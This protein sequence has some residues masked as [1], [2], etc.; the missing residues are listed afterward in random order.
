MASQRE[1]LIHIGEEH[2]LWGE[3]DSAS[4]GPVRLWVPFAY[5]NDGGVA[6]IDH[7]PGPG[8]GR[9]HEMGIGSGDVDGTVWASSLT[10]LFNGLTSSLETGKPFHY[11]EPAVYEHARGQSCLAWRIVS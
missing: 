4:L 9:V 3:D 7:R 6:F 2:D 11:Y 8:Y 5:P 1:M 10:E